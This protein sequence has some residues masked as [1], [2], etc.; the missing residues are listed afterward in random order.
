MKKMW[1][2]R[3][4][5]IATVCLSMLMIASPALAIWEWCELDPV[6][7]IDGHTVSIQGMVQG[8]PQ[9]V[10]RAIKGNILFEV[11]VPHG[12]NTKVVF[13]EK[14]AKLKITED[15][16]SSEH[17]NH[18]VNIDVALSVK[19][20]EEYPMMLKISVDG[21]V[22]GEILGNTEHELNTRVTLP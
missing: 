14:N 9:Q 4:A 3:L 6:I 19:T 1:L 10:A 18:A 21:V 7:T 13:I 17:D 11:S 2:M 12:V 16:C 5:V 22:V 15:K 20:H 8:D